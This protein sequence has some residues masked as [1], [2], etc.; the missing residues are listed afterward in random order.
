VVR[1]IL[2]RN[3]RQLLTLQG[4]PG[5]RRGADLSNLGLMV[6]GAVLIVNG[7]IREVGLTSRLESLTAA[8]GALKIDATGCVVL[9][10][11]VDSHTHLV[12]PPTRFFHSTDG[13]SSFVYD[14]LIRGDVNLVG[15]LSGR[16]LVS[17]A[18]RAL[19]ECI[20]NG[21]TT[22]E[23]KS[24]HGCDESGEL[25][26]LKAHTELQSLPLTVVSTFMGARFLPASQHARR[27]RYLNWLCDDMLPLVARRQLAEFVD[28]ECEENVFSVIE[29]RRV[30]SAARQLGFAL[31]MHAGQFGNIGAIQLGLELGVASLDHLVY[32]D[33]S[34]MDMLATSSTIATLLPGGSFY[35]GS[36]RYAPARALIDRGAAV[37]LAT[38]YNVDTS[39]SQSMQMTISLACSR[40]QMT[41]AEAISAATING[42]WA[43]RRADQI[44]SLEIGKHAD[45]LVLSVPDYREIPQRFGV[46]LVTRTIKKGRVLYRAPDS[47]INTNG[48]PL[49]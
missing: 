32:L 41:A 6:N 11:F 36:E 10:G 44:G 16:T 48:T 1:P 28:I 21:T 23:A 4:P 47:D 20:R 9:P 8:R 14:R 7:V 5:P 24:G 37:A 22:V 19:K 17:R 33:D 31:K 2:V 46:N 29:A 25:R 42:A 35:V 38:N 45:L 27:E 3:A 30:L 15:D 40:M 12:G 39:P 34:D 13:P 49:D 26:I 18:T 43:L